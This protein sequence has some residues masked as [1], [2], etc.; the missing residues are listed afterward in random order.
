MY[1]IWLPEGTLSLSKFF[2]EAAWG[3]GQEH[4]GATAFP[5]PFLA[6]PTCV[7]GQLRICATR[8]SIIFKT[9]LSDTSRALLN[10]SA[11]VEQ[12][13]KRDTSKIQDNY[14]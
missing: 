9:I 8:V 1:N 10:I 11:L 14:T 5:A 12:I 13:L 2:T 6:P 3:Q 7:H 4:R